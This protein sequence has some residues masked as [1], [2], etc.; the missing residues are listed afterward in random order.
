MHLY[1]NDMTQ[2]NTPFEVGLGWLVHL[3][4]PKDFIG[5]KALEQQAETSTKQKLVCIRME[6]K[7]IPRRGYT[8]QA[9]QMKPLSGGLP[10]E[11]GHP[12]LETGI[13]FALVISANSKIGSKLYVNIRGKQRSCSVVRRPFVKGNK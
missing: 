6:E 9:M 5:R 3:E 2:E 7:A 8:V 13:A 4:I 12:T 11:D 10:V 1:G